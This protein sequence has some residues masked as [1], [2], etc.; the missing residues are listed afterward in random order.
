MPDFYEKEKDY[1]KLYRFRTM[2]EFCSK[3]QS[4]LKLN[5]THTHTHT[6]THS[7]ASPCQTRPVRGT[8][9][10]DKSEVCSLA[11]QI[12]VVT[13]RLLPVLCVQLGSLS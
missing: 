2:A 8:D 5:T 7:P 1:L 13:F 9:S 3:T 11:R 6:H 10:Q 12:P 4:P